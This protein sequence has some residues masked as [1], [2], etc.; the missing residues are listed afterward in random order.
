MLTQQENY[1]A[2]QSYEALMMRAYNSD[3]NFERGIDS[4]HFVAL[5]D[6]PNGFSRTGVTY[7]KQSKQVRSYVLSAIGQ[8]S[9]WSLNITERTELKKWTMAITEATTEEALREG[10]E[11]LLDTTQRFNI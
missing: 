6:I 3:R 7:A 11:G 9:Q 5:Y 8:I 1:R 4:S 10:I 2:S